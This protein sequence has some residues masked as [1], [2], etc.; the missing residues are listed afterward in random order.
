MRLSRIGRPALGAIA[1]LSLVVPSGFAESPPAVQHAPGS[2]LGVNVAQ[3]GD[4]SRIEFRFP[5]GAGVTSRRN[6]QTLVLHFSRY[7]TPDMRQ[8]RVDP[9]RFL[10]TAEDRKAG[11]G[12]ELVLTLADGADAKVV[13]SDGVIAVNLF[14][15]AQ[16][17][18]ASQPASAVNRPNPVPDG[19]VVRVAVRQQAGQLTLD[20]P[21]KAPVGAAVFH[22]GQAI[23]IV[24]DAA[25]RLDLGALPRGAPLAPAA[26]PIQGADFTA[27]RIEAPA[28]EAAAARGQGGDWTVT[29]SAQ[30]L[31]QPD[32]VKIARDDASA[33]GALSIAVAGATHV[34][35]VADP[36][37]GDR[38][39]VVTALAPVK[40]VAAARTYVDL[41]LLAS[42]QGLAIQPIADDLA[43]STDGD[44]VSI[45]RPTGLALSGLRGPQAPSDNG[46]GLPQPA[47]M[48]GLVDFAGWS[49]T[50]PGGFVARYD[51]L[52]NAAAAEAGQGKGAPMQA[53]MALARFLVGSELD[54]EAIGLL[55]LNARLQPNLLGDAEFRG[56]RGAANAMAGR[57]KE[58]QA[59][60]STPV[61]AD[62]PASALWRGYVD[63]KLAQWQ[64]ARSEFHR[65][66]SAWGQF[67]PRWRSRFAL[68]D[69]EAALAINDQRVAAGEV[70]AA[71]DN[72]TDPIEQLN[73]RLVQAKLFEAE[74][75]KAGALRVYQSM[76]GVS[77]APWISAP[78]L[79]HATQIKLAQGTLTPS[80][81]ADALDGLRYRWRGDATELET[82]RSLAQIYLSM[83]RYREA[84]EAL[85]SAGQHLPDLPESV[86]LESDLNTTFRNLF[87]NGEADG[88]QPV[89]ALALFY[90]FKD[91]TPIGADGD[92]IV[93]KL[94]RR[95]VDVDLLGQAAELLKY[96]EENRLDGVPKA[97]VASDLATID[98]MNRQPEAA[99]DALN[100]SRTT[101][102]PTSLAAQRR[103]VEARAWL[104]L[105]QYDH[106]TEII[107]GDRGT[108]AANVRAE[109]AWRKQDWASSAAQLDAMLGDRW[110]NPAPLNTEEEG[111]LLR[112][113]IALSLAKDDAGLAR[114]RARYAGFVDQAQQPDALRVALAGVSQQTSSTG[115]LARAAAEADTFVGWVQAMK[116]K[117]RETPASQTVAGAAAPAKA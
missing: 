107:E 52:A 94:A 39:A 86:A 54:F 71:L 51:A 72:A 59:E 117:F 38:I 58:A 45:G 82:I 48:P 5:G 109:V 3:S 15:A 46:P 79:L 30:A 85:R 91:L 98:V 112:C 27:L 116:Q 9:P 40:G 17:A 49:R 42:A 4:F 99:I 63:A 12:L 64:D 87:L 13:Q 56:L 61:A 44:L 7:L 70:Q 24:F 113:A 16:T 11:G 68:A 110:R 6:G 88:L 115:D 97:E 89:Q 28:G 96:Q 83:G 65:G 67:T 14:A 10:K 43:V 55:N 26:Q 32:Q 108:D 35:W 22:R 47:T 60:L 76:T 41:A 57:Y 69:A 92:L 33:T 78:A 2:A 114:L 95:L 73:A 62:D 81:A 75:D 25:A 84:L 90:D 106:A 53:R 111:R 36:S 23:W 37:V 19:G 31:Q 105:G 66:A 80:Q 77:D 104:M 103:V 74:G 100:E 20:F 102:L 8:L 93:R 1:A 21:W 29:L 101:L 18:Q 34:L 50:G